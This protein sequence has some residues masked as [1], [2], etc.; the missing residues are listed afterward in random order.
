G[1]GA[2]SSTLN[3]CLV[4]SNSTP[5]NGGG[6]SFSTLTNCTVVANTAGQRGGGTYGGTLYNSVVFF[7]TAQLQGSNYNN[8]Y[9][10]VFGNICCTIPAPG[11]GV[12]T[13]QPAFQVLLG[14]PESYRLQPYSPCINNGDNA[15]A[16]G[17]TDLDG[18][19]RIVADTVDIGAYENPHPG[20][21]L[22]YFWAQQYGL[23]TYGYDDSDGDG[24]NNWQEWKAGTN[25]TNAASVLAMNSVTNVMSGATLTWQSVSGVTYYVQ[26]SS[27]L[28]DE[29]FF[30]SI[31]SNIVGQA[32]STSYTDT[33]A[34]NAG[35]YF[36]RVGVQ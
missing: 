9:T 32:V 21:V 19:P 2:A 6:T 23:P 25:P 35:P 22:P 26:R 16:T 30:S 13:N 27:D 29:T 18:N 34:T 7:N 17:A 8:Y 33:T 3:N 11:A 14:L 31:Q 36:Y 5:G 24:L 4:I 1:G 10:S 12:I 15:C 20:L 28:T